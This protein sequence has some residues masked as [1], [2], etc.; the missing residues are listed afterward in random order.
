MSESKGIVLN[1][2]FEGSYTS[3]E[4]KIA[5]EIIDFFLTDKEE[6]YAYNNPYGQFPNKDDCEYKYMLLC[7]SAKIKRGD[8]GK[9]EES[10][11]TFKLRYLLKIEPLHY[12]GACD[13][14]KKSFLDKQKEVKKIIDERDI[15]YGGKKLYEIYGPNDESLYVTFKVKEMYEPENGVIEVTTPGYAFQRNKGYVTENTHKEA[16]EALEK[17]IEDKSLWKKCS[18]KKLDK[19]KMKRKSAPKTF[20]DFIL[21]NDSEECFTNMLCSMLGHNDVFNNFVK[22]FNKGKIPFNNV[23][24]DVKR[25]VKIDKTSE[26]KGGRTDICAQE[27]GNENG[28]RIVI[29]NKVFSGL[30]GLDDNGKTQLTVYYE[31]WASK[32]SNPICFI[33]CPD[34]RVDEIKSEI[35]PGMKDKYQFVTY[36]EIAEFLERQIFSNYT[37]EGYIKDAI[38]AFRNYG[39]K[40]KFELFEELF[41][42]AIGKI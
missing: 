1:K 42:E 4:G 37:F 15:S 34:F 20:L 23:K 41:L 2:P 19:S 12:F 10:S 16:F 26:I 36:S 30:N 24:Y 14:K 39:Y 17:K 31:N 27:S 33:T 9:K 6:Q 18:L 22:E 3:E 40:D 7:S 28:Q 21:K 13:D 25:E 29:E 11:S 5:H 35:E 38:S 8:K 32:N